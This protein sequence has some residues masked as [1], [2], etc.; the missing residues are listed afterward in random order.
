MVKSPSVAQ[1]IIDLF[2]TIIWIIKYFFLSLIGR[3][4]QSTENRTRAEN[5]RKRQAFIGK[6]Q[7]P[8]NLGCGPGG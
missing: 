8:I 1:R 4:P 7:K 5:E 2:F 3:E 6:M